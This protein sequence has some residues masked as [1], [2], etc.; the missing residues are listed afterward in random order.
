VTIAPTPVLLVCGPPCVGK[1]VVGWEV[2]S[3]LTG[4]GVKAA[5]VDLAQIGFSRPAP[6][7]DPDNHRIR[8]RNLAAMWPTFR[9]AG[10]RYLV[11]SGGVEQRDV[12]STYADALPGTVLSMCRL[13]AGPEQ[14]TERILLRGRG[15]GPAIPGDELKGRSPDYLRSFADRAVATS[16]RLDRAGLDAVCVDT[17]GRSVDEV[18]DRVRAQASG[19]P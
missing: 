5:Y 2:F 12:V 9:G 10:A 6:D 13:R 4:S 16:E 18:A 8:A 7:D 1:S 3:R 11:L 15:G 17:D 19:W 14:L